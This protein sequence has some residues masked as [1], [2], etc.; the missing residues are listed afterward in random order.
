LFIV[1]EG[2]SK[3]E[4]SKISN[5]LKMYFKH[6]YCSTMF[7]QTIDLNT[8]FKKIKRFEID[9]LI[10]FFISHAASMQHYK[11]KIEYGLSYKQYVISD[12]FLSTAYA[13][14]GYGHGVSLNIMYDVI[15]ST[16]G[17]ITPDITFYTPVTT[18]ELLRDKQITKNGI[19]VHD[20][21]LTGYLELSKLFPN[22]VILDSKK[23]LDS[24]IKPV[25]DKLIN[26]RQIKLIKSM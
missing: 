23:S 24:Q 9:N 14:Y 16:L 13:L 19:E 8:Y 20:K 2:V 17:N 5:Y 18:E 4:K 1:I 11:D 6:A 15:E 10:K 25:L 21:I 3:F 12:G 22:W 7:T 26:A